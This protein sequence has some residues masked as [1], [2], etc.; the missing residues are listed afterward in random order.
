M[1]AFFSYVS[2][3]IP[4]LAAKKRLSL[5]QPASPPEQ[6][7]NVDPWLRW[8][9]LSQQPDFRSRCVCVYWCVYWGVCVCVCVFVCVYGCVW[10]GISM[11]VCVR[12]CVRLP[13][14]NRRSALAAC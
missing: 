14:C 1:A 2:V 7:T 4:V 11:Y 5:R 12:T 8:Q 6:T 3:V 9:Q 13:A 10:I